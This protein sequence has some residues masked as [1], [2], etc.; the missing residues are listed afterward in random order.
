MISS[1]AHISA[2]N[3]KVNT[4][5]RANQHACHSR[6]MK[7]RIVVDLGDR[8]RRLR[9]ERGL[10]QVEV[11]K[12]LNITRSAVSQTES[13]PDINIRAENLLGYAELFGMT[14]DELLTGEQNTVAETAQKYGLSTQARRVAYE[15]DT[16]NNY[17]RELIADLV[18]RAAEAQ[19][20]ASK[21]N[22]DLDTIMS[23]I[24]TGEQLAK[25][26]LEEIELKKRD[27]M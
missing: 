17:M 19:Q 8:I 5:Y 16:L 26:Y 25:E 24:E 11:A 22:L 6:S 15:Y 3:S 27:A 1:S 20:R 7:K 13:K 9:V 12:K 18:M 23:A 14:I 21:I 2:L 4:D 10:S